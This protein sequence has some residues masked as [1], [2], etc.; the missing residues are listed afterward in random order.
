MTVWPIFDLVNIIQLY[1]GKEYY[2]LLNL[3]GNELN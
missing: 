2:M 3:P 1:S